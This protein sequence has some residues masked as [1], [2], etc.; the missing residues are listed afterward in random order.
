MFGDWLSS[1]VWLNT[2]WQHQVFSYPLEGPLAYTVLHPSL[3]IQQLMAPYMQRKSSGSGNTTD[4]SIFI[5]W[6]TK[7]PFCKA[8]MLR[9]SCTYLG[10]CVLSVD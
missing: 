1:I 10:G 5:A 6:D 3:P 2:D 7:A 4:S 8:F 9:K